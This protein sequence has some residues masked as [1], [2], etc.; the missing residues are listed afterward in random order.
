MGNQT[1]FKLTEELINKLDKFSDSPDV[2]A[3]KV[4]AI[5]KKA[6]ITLTDYDLMA[7]SCCFVGRMAATEPTYSWLL[8][9]ARQ[10]NFLFHHAHYYRLSTNIA[11]DLEVKDTTQALDVLDNMELTDDETKLQA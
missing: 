9:L 4:L 2:I 7:F 8:Q 3:A 10:L 6:D 5:L 11:K 1:E